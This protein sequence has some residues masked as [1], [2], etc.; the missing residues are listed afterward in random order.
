LRL[1]IETSVWSY[2]FADHLPEKQKATRELLESQ[3]A[4]ELFISALVFDELSATKDYGLRE[5][6]LRTLSDAEPVKLPPNPQVV[7]ISGKLVDLG[8]LKPRSENDALHIAFAIVHGMDALVSWD[9]GDIVRLKT[10]RG[11]SAVARLFGFH[12]VDLVTPEEL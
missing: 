5:K 9:T 11:V 2:R 1:Y 7:E 10:R 3:S 4:H 12:E 8:V 6:L